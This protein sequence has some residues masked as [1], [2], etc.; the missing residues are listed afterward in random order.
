M[1]GQMFPTP[2]VLPEFG[3]MHQAG[4]LLARAAKNKSPARF[5]YGVR[6]ILQGLQTRGI[7]R[8]HVSQT[9]NDDRAAIPPV[10]R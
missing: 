5:M 4:G 3:L 6:K 7:D 1:L 8:R 2:D 9:K 10:D